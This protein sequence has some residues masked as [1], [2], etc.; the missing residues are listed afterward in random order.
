MRILGT[1]LGAGMCAGSLVGAAEALFVLQSRSPAEYQAFGYAFLLYGVV[2]GLVGLGVGVVLLPWSRRLAP[3]AAFSTALVLVLGAMALVLGHHLADV[4]LYEGDGVPLSAM[5]AVV[6]GASVLGVVTSMM[7]SNLLQKTPLFALT[8]A[9]G[10]V[11]AW[12]GGVVLSWIF[13]L[14]PAPP[15]PEAALAAQR[16]PVDL[17][18]RPDLIVVVVSGLRADALGR[19]LTPTLDAFGAEAVVFDQAVSSASWTRPAVASLFTSMAPSSHGAAGPRDRL[20]PAL[21]TLAEVLSARGYGTVG[22][23]NHPDISGSLGFG[24]GF[25]RYAYEPR[26]PMGAAESTSALTLYRVVRELRARVIGEVDAARG[27]APASV[28]LS[29]GVALLAERPRRPTL[30]SVQLAEPLEP[31]QVLEATGAAPQLHALREAY[32][33]RVRAVDA[34]IAGFFREL[35]GLG[36][37]AGATIVVTG[38]HGVELLD[39]GGWGN[40][41]TLY[42]EQL[43]VP[44]LIK[45]PHGARAG[46]R[47]P[48]QVRHVDVAPTLLDLAGAATPADWQGAELFTDSFD[49]DLAL[50]APPPG[51]LEDGLPPGWAPP[52]WTNHPASRDA[53]SEGHH[54]GYHLASLRRGGL[55]TILSR[56]VPRGDARNQ[57][58]PQFYD[59]VADPREQVNLAP[60]AST[61]AAAMRAALE[62][63]VDDRSRRGVGRRSGDADSVER[64]RLCEI[65]YLAPQ[66]CVGCP[67]IAPH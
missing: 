12:G 3:G 54:G 1:G 33:E 29:A 53:L 61:D 20:S 51:S 22:I 32:S 46:V 39:H 66:D 47:V 6:A 17:T 40:G 37:Y 45:L 63:L 11:A 25:E 2:G 43:L 28:V 34:A 59:L 30:L 24:Q 64:C 35:H 19:G 27:H 38:D 13:A 26:L 21:T 9:K 44:L 56:R 31:F 52:N 67:R 4:R 55:K 41:D 7:G 48:W 57:R 10:L 16:P 15:S 18:G 23:P 49:A 5:I 8:T 58:A 36:R 60:Q 14:S 65:G 42:D 62:S 50:C